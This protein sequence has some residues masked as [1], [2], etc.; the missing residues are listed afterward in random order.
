[1]FF[2]KIAEQLDIIPQY[3][4]DDLLEYKSKINFAPDNRFI[5]GKQ[6]M[7]QSFYNSDPGIKLNITAISAYIY[8]RQYSVLKNMVQYETSIVQ[9]SQE[10]ATIEQPSRYIC[11]MGELILVPLNGQFTIATEDFVESNEF[12]LS[13]GNV[14]R[15]NNRV[16]SSIS[17]D[18]DF[19]GIVY[20]FVDFD[21]KKYLM[22]HDWN[23]IYSI[24]PD[25]VFGTNKVIPQQTSSAY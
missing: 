11:R 6:S 15:I 14:Y 1:M 10:N 18:I 7:I 19:I 4:I 21:L 9:F 13:T 16:N 3:F 5:L 2:N 17:T 8:S 12:T 20:S 22:P 24:Q 25:E 23:S